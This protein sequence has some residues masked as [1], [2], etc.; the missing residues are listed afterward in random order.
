MTA[1]E[2]LPL[3][4]GVRSRGQG[5]WSAK[6]PAH[7]DKSPSL[8]IAEGDRGLL[9][10]CWAG[11]TIEEITSRLGVTVADLFFDAPCPDGQKPI[12]KPPKT[13]RVAL[14]FRLELAALDRRL[15][16][17]RVLTAIRGLDGATLTDEMRE[18]L[19]AVVASTYRGLERADLFEGIADTLRWRAFH[20]RMKAHAA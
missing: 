19:M 13:D 11:C 7:A 6:C 9:L 15:R 8:T 12:S 3:L 2:L 18:R 4:E 14:A 17:E 10:K 5:K 16:A 20:E 1:A